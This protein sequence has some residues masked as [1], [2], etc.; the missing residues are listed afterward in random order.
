[1]TLLEWTD[2]L[3]RWDPAFW[4]W[5]MA[6]GGYAARSADEW[7]ACYAQWGKLARALYL[8]RVHEASAK[9]RERR[10]RRRS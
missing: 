5:L 1:M 10:K 9:G 4:I 3:H 8:H 6:N 7:A 2:T